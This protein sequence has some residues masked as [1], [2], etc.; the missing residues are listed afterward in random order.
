MT[1]DAYLAYT[2][3][4]FRKWAPL[5]DAF[6]APIGFAYRAAVRAI[7]P[8]PGLTVLDLCTG[9]GKIALRCARA[10]ALV[11]AIDITPEMLAKA[12]HK[13]G[14]L[15][16]GFA[17]MDARHLPFPDHHFAVTSLSFA[18][19]DMPRRVRLEVLREAARVTRNRLVILDYALPHN[20]LLHRTFT[21]AISLFESA[22]FPQ[23][24]HEGLS[25]LLLAAGLPQAATTTRLPC[26]AVS[27]VNLA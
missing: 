21:R 24:A 25:P 23:F 13:A 10:G 19:H 20:P 6:A 16:I 3:R 1:H 17:L 12:R 2:H 18:L 15:P 8:D 22:Y 7:A 26:F 14:A 27:T 5:Y 4:F 9:T 11:T